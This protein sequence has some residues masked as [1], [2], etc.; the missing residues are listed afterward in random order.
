[1]VHR[2]ISRESPI[3]RS[4]P[5]DR[6]FFRVQKI[7]G[8]EFFFLEEGL[9]EWPAA[10]LG[11]PASAPRVPSNANRGLFLLA[12]PLRRVQLDHR[13]SAHTKIRWRGNLQPLPRHTGEGAGGCE[14]PRERISRTWTPEANITSALSVWSA[15]R[16]VGDGDL[17]R[18]RDRDLAAPG[19]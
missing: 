4:P 6:V 18:W 9:D 16:D 12:L 15:E 19:H 2:H 7:F 3:V 5:V 11:A 1:M 14:E 17:G 8:N 10:L 13:A